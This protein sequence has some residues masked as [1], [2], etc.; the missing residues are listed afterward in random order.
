MPLPRLLRLLA[1][2]PA[3]LLLFVPA[4]LEAK[5]KK[6]ATPPAVEFSCFVWQ[7]IPIPELFYR[8]G[9]QYLPVKLSPGQRSQP[10]PI[11]G[12]DALELFQRSAKAAGK[13]GSVS[14]ADYDLVGRA[15][16]LNGTKRMLF[17]IEATKDSGKNSNSH[18]FRLHGMDDSLEAFPAGSFRFVNLTPDLLRIE[19]AGAILELPG[20]AQKVVTPEIPESGG[21]L[22]VV[23]KNETGRHLL[24]N[25]LLAQRTGRELVLIAPPAGGRTDL[26]VKFLSDSIPA[27]SKS[28]EKA[29]SRK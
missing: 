4:T 14:A 29:P 18:P 16:L 21:F 2:F 8:Q 28:G 12:A 3:I 6:R 26:T 9:Q 13:G 17:L 20:G 24:E 15:P 25:R 7:D 19:L 10:C 22:P 27:S 5:G 1:V 23:I 11:Q